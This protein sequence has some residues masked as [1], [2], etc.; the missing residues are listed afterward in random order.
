LFDSL[1]LDVLCDNEDSTPIWR[2][3]PASR[4]EEAEELDSVEGRAA[5]RHPKVVGC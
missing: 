1:V 4:E 3:K 2:R 5:L